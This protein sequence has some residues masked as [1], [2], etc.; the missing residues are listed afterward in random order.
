MRLAK[1]YPYEKTIC[2]PFT[3]NHLMIIHLIFSLA[4]YNQSI[5]ARTLQLTIHCKSSFSGK[6]YSWILQ[7][8]L[9]VGILVS[10]LIQAKLCVWPSGS[11]AGKSVELGHVIL[12][13]VT[14]ERVGHKTLL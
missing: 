4:I 3:D 8:A 13:Y 9:S 5:L 6:F 12:H 1:V 10:L 11:F 14:E 7:G 2:L